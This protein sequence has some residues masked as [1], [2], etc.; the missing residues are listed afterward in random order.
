MKNKLDI[1]LEGERTIVMRRSFNAPRELVFDAWTKPEHLAQWYG[2][3][4]SSLSVC[5]VELRPGGKWRL[6]IRES[7]GQDY[8]FGGKYIEVLRPERLVHTYVFDPYPNDEAMVTVTFE[9][10]EGGTLLTETTVHA[11]AEGRDGH[12]ASGFEVGATESMDRLEELLAELQQHQS[13]H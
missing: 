11:T 13:I 5:E 4:G 2:M 10:V 12:I 1:T 3:R 8:G 9:T 7:D 6:V